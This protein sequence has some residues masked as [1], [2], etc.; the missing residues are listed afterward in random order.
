MPGTP[1]ILLIT[2][3]DSGRH[4]GC[5]GVNTVHTPNL[6][7][8]A[9]RGVRLSR[10]FAAAPICCASRAAMLTGTYPQ[11][12]GQMDLFFP[13]F[14]WSLHNP[15]WHVSHLL[16]GLG[17]ETHLFGL[18]HEV[19]AVAELG[20]D[21]LHD[22]TGRLPIATDLAASVAG[23]LGARKAGDRPFFA[24]IGFFETHWPFDWGNCRAD[25]GRG[26]F[27]PPYLQQNDVA[28]RTLAQFQ[29]AMRRVDDAV[30]II[31]SALRAANLE[32]D[33]IVIFNTDHGME[34]P[35]AK[36]HLYDP[37]LEIAMIFSAPGRI[38]GGRVCDHL[39]SNIDWLPTLFNL[40][41]TP[42]PEHIDGRSFAAGLCRAD[43]APHRDAVF[44]MYQ[45][46][47]SRC[48]RTGRYKLI[49]N[50]NLGSLPAQSSGWFLHYADARLDFDDR[51]PRKRVVDLYP[52]VEFYDLQTDPC[53]MNN[54]CDDPALREEFAALDGRLW[55]WMESVNDSLLRGPERTPFYE[56]AITDYQSWRRQCPGG[57]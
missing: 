37:G 5:Y 6:D 33:T 20:F 15:R 18:Q 10:C 26:V 13:P 11:T 43:A 50:F 47:A 56:K 52:M 27:I 16:R 30:G 35:R 48:V 7:D 39:A 23:F 29:G 49:R 55:Q 19:Q 1:H 34:L 36:W 25:D 32:D 28:R 51:R 38:S 57:Q 42:A 46:S 8:L 53:E 3:H 12:N 24:Q 54:R 41:G 9:A 4:L 44:A 14:N 22:A 31:L 45:K 2:T 21:L 40:L 17:Y